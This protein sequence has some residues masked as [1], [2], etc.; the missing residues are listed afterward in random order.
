MQYDSK[1]IRHFSKPKFVFN[2]MSLQYKGA[3]Y[4]QNHITQDVQKTKIHRFKIHINCFQ[5]IQEYLCVTIKI[6]L[7]RLLTLLYH[8]VKSYNTTQITR[9]TISDNRIRWWQYWIA[10]LFQTFDAS[11]PSWHRVTMNSTHAVNTVPVLRL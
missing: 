10:N 11:Q 8:P 7:Q 4:L 3:G 5:I 1:E 6:Y 9:R 2:N